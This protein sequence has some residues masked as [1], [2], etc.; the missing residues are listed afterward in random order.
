MAAIT[1]RYAIVLGALALAIYGLVRL[2]DA[3]TGVE[4]PGSF[5]VGALSLLLGGSAA[6]FMGGE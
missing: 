2:L 6:L 3:M 4:L 1:I 5:I